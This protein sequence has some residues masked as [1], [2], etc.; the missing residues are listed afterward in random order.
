MGLENCFPNSYTN[1]MIQFLFAIPSVRHAALLAQSQSFYYN[2]SSSLWCELGFLFHMMTLRRALFN[3]CQDPSALIDEEKVVVPS[4]FQRTL[5]QMPEA[6]ALSLLENQARQADSTQRVLNFTRFLLQQLQI[7]LDN[8]SRLHA[9]SSGN[10]IVANLY[11][12]EQ[13]FRFSIE[14]KIDYLQS[15]ISEQQPLTSSLALD[16]VFS[17]SSE[18]FKQTD[19]TNQSFSSV[20][21]H[22]LQK[23]AFMRSDHIM[24]SIRCQ[25]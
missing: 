24:I 22:S 15:N 21:W 25:S 3:S 6:A 19:Q 17:S 18:G 23:E 13:T 1:A 2:N 4:S 9:S 11:P 8:E 10:A 7:E 20:L 5:Q 14:T 12:L 16:L